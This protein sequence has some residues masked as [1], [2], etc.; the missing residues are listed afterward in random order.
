MKAPKIP[1]IGNLTARHLN[2][3][4]APGG[5]G[6][7]NNSSPLTYMP[8]GHPSAFASTT[9]DDGSQLRVISKFTSNNSKPVSKSLITYLFSPFL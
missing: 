9:I 6:G 5:E 7:Q 3:T 2:G 8:E 1:G 4:V